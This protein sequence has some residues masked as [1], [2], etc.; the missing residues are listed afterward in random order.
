MLKNFIKKIKTKHLIAAGILV[1]A[2]ISL[3]FLI[4]Q[5]ADEPEA[6]IYPKKVTVE[7]ILPDTYNQGVIKTVASVNPETK[8]NVSSL[9]AG[10]VRSVSFQIGDE[11]RAGQVLAVL[12]N[13]STLTSLNNSRTSLI[14]TQGSR[15][16][17]ERIVDENIKQAELGVENAQ[18]N[19]EAARLGLDSARSS[20]NNTIALRRKANADTI[21]AAVTSYNSY[22]NSVFEVLDNA[23]NIL[24]IENEIQIPGFER[25]LGAKDLGSLN[26]AR[27]GYYNLQ[28]KYQNL[29]NRAINADNITSEMTGII[30]LLEDAKNHIEQMIILLDNTVS[31]EN[32]SAAALE[33]QKNIFYGLRAGFVGT[34]NSGQGLKNTLDNLDLAYKAEID[35]LENAVKSAENRVNSAELGLTNARI[36]LE[37]VKQSGRQQLLNSD[38]AVL[39]AQ[40]QLSLLQTQASDLTI[41]APISGKITAKSVEYGAQIN[42]GQTIAE[43]SQDQ[44]LKIKFSLNSTEIYRLD[45]GQEIT[46][47]GG[48]KARLDNIAPAADPLTKQVGVEAWFDNQNN[49]LIAGTFIDVSIPVK[50]LDLDSQESLLVP[51]KAVLIGQNESRIFTVEEME[52]SE[53]NAGLARQRIVATGQLSG[54][55]IE[56]TSG[57]TAGEKIVIEGAK[58]LKDGDLINF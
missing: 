29:K 2:A 32:L 41:T 57:L 19:L 10:T 58:N 21:N 54:A 7:T 4:N 27:S 43:I 55:L 13:D 51:L 23:N 9:I 34:I 38:S 35:S 37:N 48:L 56:I 44:A 40:G 18:K 16:A 25:G 39:N 22:L 26:A 11:V 30:Q 53:A 36:S 31:G 24:P 20:L 47:S 5:G 15:L 14:N 3:V 45:K 49:E 17:L 52:D 6:A 28:S 12:N 8:V 42:P 33:A 46:L 50:P 1:V